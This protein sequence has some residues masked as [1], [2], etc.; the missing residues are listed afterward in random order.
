MAKVSNFHSFVVL[1]LVSLWYIYSKDL[2]NIGAGSSICLHHFLDLRLHALQRH[3]VSPSLTPSS[4]SSQFQ[5][6]SSLVLFLITYSREF[7]H[8]VKSVSMSKFTSQE[9]EVLQ[10]GGNQVKY[11][12][13]ALQVFN[14]FF[15]WRQMFVLVA[16]ETFLISAC[17]RNIF[18]KL[19]PSTA[20]TSRQQ[21]QIITFTCCLVFIIQIQNMFC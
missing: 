6:F 5:F 19:G 21:V 20:E 3:S 7:T 1:D 8:R 10:N 17:Q 13:L 11:L 4:S 2:F 15:F 18:E 9:V 14:F 12:M 16:Y